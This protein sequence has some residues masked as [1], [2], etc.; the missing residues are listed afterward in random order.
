MKPTTIQMGKC[1]YVQIGYVPEMVDEEL[2]FHQRVV[3]K[4]NDTW[5]M[6][7]TEEINNFF[8]ALRALDIC[9]NVGGN[10]PYLPKKDDDFPGTF[11]IDETESQWLVQYVNYSN[12][13]EG[14]VVFPSADVLQRVV[15]FEDIILGHMFER[16][17][18]R[19]QISGELEEKIEKAA[20]Q[21]KNVSH[22]SYMASS[23]IDSFTVELSTN[24]FSFFVQYWNIHVKKNN[25][26]W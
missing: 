4:M 13:K 9:K 10:Y 3:I 23:S 21:C 15:A 18:F 20:K 5:I 1:G 12:Q 14:T 26:E 2:V 22:L 25:S 24:F 7:S 17:R 16:F 8:I 6:M 11:F 19:E